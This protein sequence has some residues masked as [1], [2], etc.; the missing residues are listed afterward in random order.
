MSMPA[1]TRWMSPESKRIKT[2]ARP[3]TKAEERRAITAAVT[4]F[5]R[6]ARGD[7]NRRF[8]VLWAELRVDKRARPKLLPPRRIAVVIVDYG[9]LRSLEFLVDNGGRVVGERT[10]SLSPPFAADEVKEARA[11]AEHDPRVAR[12]IQTGASFDGVFTPG[13]QGERRPRLVGLRYAV[14]KRGRAFDLRAAVVVDLS[15]Q[16]IASFEDVHAQSG[17]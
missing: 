4:A 10:L 14:S 11:I 17:S 1:S 8:R 2:I 16:A 6:T 12:L 7:G 3:L 13:G 9:G 15:A 5:G